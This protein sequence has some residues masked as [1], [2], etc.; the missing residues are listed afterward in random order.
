MSA[1]PARNAA[2]E[3]PVSTTRVRDPIAP[4]TSTYQ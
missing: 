3:T 2:P 4:E 1:P